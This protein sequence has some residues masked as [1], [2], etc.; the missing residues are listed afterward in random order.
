M[1]TELKKF[2]EQEM[3][4][5]YTIPGRGGRI[6][7][8]I[9]NAPITA[10]DNMKMAIKEKKAAFMPSYLYY[11]AFTPRIIPDNEARAFTVDGGTMLS[12]PEGFKDMFGIT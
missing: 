12:H 11:Q 8:H 1:N 9:Y 3:K 10:R 6:D 2:D 7:M 5:R 4:I